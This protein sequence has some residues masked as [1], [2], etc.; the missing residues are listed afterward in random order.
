MQTKRFI[1]LVLLLPLISCKDKN[2]VEKATVGQIQNPLSGHTFFK[3]MENDEKEKYI[4]EPCYALVRQYAVFENEI[5]LNYGQEFYYM[6]IKSVEKRNDSIIYRTIFKTP[7]NAYFDSDSLI[8]F[9]SLDSEKKFWTINKEEY[10]DSLY[11][12]T[13]P[14]VKEA[15]PCPEW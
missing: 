12:S 7:W 11:A 15:D 8:V 13:V 5:Y 10:T 1:L 9:K 14:L 4:Y 6:D 3:V 2:T